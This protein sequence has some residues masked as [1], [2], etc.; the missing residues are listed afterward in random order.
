[1]FDWYLDICCMLMLMK[2]WVEVCCVMV[3]YIFGLF[4]WV[5]VFDDFEEK[6]CNFYFVEFMIFIVKGG[7]IEMGIDVILFGIQIYGGMGF[8]E[9][10]GVVQYWC[11]LCIMIIYEGMI[12]IQVNDLLFRKLMCD[13]GVMVCV[14]FGEVVGMVEVLVVFVWFE[15]QVIVKCLG[16]G[17]QVWVKVIEWLVVEV[18]NGLV[19]LLIVVVFYLYFVVIVCGGWFMGKVV[20]VV[21]GYLE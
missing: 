2:L 13:Q 17:L 1:M 19:G 6:K 5:Y 9:E 7:G 11:D 10:I 20:L 18:K 3:Y 12:G 21:V 8:I 14:V 16:V 15:L 4:D